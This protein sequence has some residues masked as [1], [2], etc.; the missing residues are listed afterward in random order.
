MKFIHL[1]DLHLGKRLSDY[2][3][4]EDQEFILNKILAT[5]DEEKADGV[6]IAGD[7]YD[8]SVPSA[9]AVQ[10]FDCFLSELAKRDL[11][12]FVISGNHDSPERIAF[13]SSI[14]DTRG[15]HLSPV[16]D[17]KVAPTVLRDEFGE[18]NVYMLPF[19]KPAHVRRFFV[20]ADI[21]SYTDAVGVA[22]KA[23]NVDPTKR[24]IL[25][26]HQFVTGALKAGSEE[27]VTVGGTD[28]VDAS[29]FA[30]FDY[31]AL[32]HIHGTQSLGDDRIRYCGTPL[33][34]SLSEVDHVKSVTIVELG[35][36]EEGV[37]LGTAPLAPLRD[38]HRIK[39]EFEEITA[40]TFYAGKSYATD[41][42]SITLTDEDDVPNAFARL[43]EI[44]KN[45]MSLEYDNTRTRT[46]S[47]I[48]AAEETEQKTT[49][50]LFAELFEMQNKRPLSEKQIAYLEK[51]IEEV[52]EDGE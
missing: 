35:S 49:I 3:M 17:G 42:V 13:G 15:V 12:V 45:I 40:P 31:V 23:M 50:E 39:G 8:K 18:I 10:L 46:S 20:D 9:E 38:M 37:T 33:K 6:F 48:T 14:M 4:L 22:I 24:N 51:L 21:Q 11:Q 44:Y 16:Y 26:S 1:S 29:V 28:N 19:V 7:V 43:R 27:T 36:K 52:E 41:Y 30:P 34:Y 25:I 2:S 47:L 32:G 5:V